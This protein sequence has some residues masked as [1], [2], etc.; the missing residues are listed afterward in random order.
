MLPFLLPVWKIQFDSISSEALHDQCNQWIARTSSGDQQQRSLLRHCGASSL[1]WSIC[2]VKLNN[3]LIGFLSYSSHISPGYMPQCVLTSIQVDLYLTEEVNRS[4]ATCRFGFIW[5]FTSWYHHSSTKQVYYAL[6]VIC[7][8][9]PSS[10]QQFLVFGHNMHIFGKKQKQ[11]QHQES[12]WLCV[13]K[14]CFPL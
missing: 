4:S 7:F 9:Q 10:E 14:K 8:N 11:T 13:Q 2:F 6:S 1:Q 5:L 3:E 12:V